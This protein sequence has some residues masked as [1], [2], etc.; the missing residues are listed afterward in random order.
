MI[1][2]DSKMKSYEKDIQI[3]FEALKELLNPPREPRPR[4]GFK[5]G[6]EKE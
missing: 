5:R 6:D 2:Q 1:K 3:I 4:I